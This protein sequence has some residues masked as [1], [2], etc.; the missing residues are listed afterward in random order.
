MPVFMRGRI[1]RESASVKNAASDI[2]FRRMLDNRAFVNAPC[3]V[4]L[5]EKEFMTDKKL[6][7]SEQNLLITLEGLFTSVHIITDDVSLYNQ[8]KKRQI[9]KMCSL[10]GAT[11]V[12]V[13]NS[14]ERYIAGYKL[15]DKSYLIK[16]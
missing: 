13:I 8:R 16:F 4:S 3:P 12:K 6:S 11:D 14:A 15:G 2:V 10:D 1:F 5:D 9:K 7:D